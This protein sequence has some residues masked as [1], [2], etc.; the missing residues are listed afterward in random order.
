MRVFSIFW[1]VRNRKNGGKRLT[2]GI[3][4]GFAPPSEWSIVTRISRKRTATSRTGCDS[5]DEALISPPPPR[6]LRDRGNSSNERDD[7]FCS[8]SVAKRTWWSND[9]FHAANFAPP[10]D[11][12]EARRSWGTHQVGNRGVEKR[13]RK[14]SLRYYNGF[15]GWERQLMKARRFVFLIT[16]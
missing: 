13:V 10:G 14:V 8:P 16:L 4:S 2:S 7:L 6:L 9:L 15:S 12:C 1:Q 5:H 3:A 11:W